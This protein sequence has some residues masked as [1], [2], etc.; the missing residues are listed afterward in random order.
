MLT[1]CA[2]SLLPDTDLLW[3]YLVDNRQ[4][5]HHAY[6]F[7]WPLFWILMAGLAGLAAKLLQ[8]PRA[9][10]YIG[11]SL[12]ALLLHM[13]LDTLAG[14]ISW[15]APFRDHELRLVE[16]PSRHSWWV[17]NFV[18]HWTMALEVL[19]LAAFASALFRDTGRGPRRGGTQG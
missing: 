16:V 1:A 19:I 10:P 13:L 11:V 3:F 5:V 9:L 7:H 12:A 15:L 18:L 6:L 14:G 2:A 17:W 4:T 8:R